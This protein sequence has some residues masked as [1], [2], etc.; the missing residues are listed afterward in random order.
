VNSEAS[1]VNYSELQNLRKTYT[2]FT[3]RLHDQNCLRNSQK[4]LTHCRAPISSSAE[5]HIR[6]VLPNST[7]A[8][9]MRVASS[10]GERTGPAAQSIDHSRPVSWA[11]G[12][13]RRI[14]GCLPVVIVSTVEMKPSRKVPLPSLLIP[15]WGM[16]RMLVVA[17]NDRTRPR[18]QVRLAC[19][20][21]RDP[22]HASFDHLLRACSRTVG[23]PRERQG[24]CRGETN[25]LVRRNLL[26]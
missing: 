3:I 14:R 7:A 12:F 16:I 13:W 22:R 9:K 19:V 26:P 8:L 5:R 2:H 18:R 10:G 23:M 24:L 25:A 11:A 15:V 4:M 6:E 17:K 21:L 1:R 20:L